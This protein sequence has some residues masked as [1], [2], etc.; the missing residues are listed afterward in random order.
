MWRYFTLRKIGLVVVETFLLLCCGLIAFYFYLA[1]LPSNIFEYAYVLSKALAIAVAFQFFLYLYDFYGFQVRQ[2]SIKFISRLMRAVVSAVIVSCIINFTFN[3]LAFTYGAFTWNLILSSLFVIFWHT[4]FC[5]YMQRRSPQTN[6]LVIGAS[7]LAV[8]AVREIICRPELG[9]KVVGFVAGTSKKAEAVSS[10]NSKIIGGY[11]DLK[12]L[13]SRYDVNYVIV[14]LSDSRKRLPIENLLNFKARGM[15]IESVEDFYERITGKIPAENLRPS[16]LVFNAGFDISEDIFLKKRILSISLSFVLLILTS[17]ILLLSAI[18]IK[19]DSRGPVF[20]RQERV[21]RNGRVF[22]LV[23]FRSMRQ[24]AEKLTGPVLST[25][26]GDTR[27]TRVGRFIRWMRIDELPQMYNILRGDMDMVGPQPERPVFVQ[28]FSEEIPYYPI[29]HVIRPGVTGWA[30]VNYGYADR[31]E[32]T[33]EKL[34]YDLFYIKNMSFALD[35]MI[36][37]ETVKTILARK[38]S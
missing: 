23:K 6:M 14:G 11:N 15:L 27:V 10:V 32:H 28:R 19:L 4:T 34:Q 7:D 17:P 22:K 30:K 36:L 35:I 1:K 33:I 12:N 26:R 20:Y 16:W 5:I 2:L 13:V 24:D 18:A 3:G 31:S 8:T 25:P 21:G 37:F 29:R 38:G 9:I